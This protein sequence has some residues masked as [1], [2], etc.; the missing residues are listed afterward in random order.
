[1]AYL[2]I[3]LVS[4]LRYR[5]IE[6]CLARFLSASLPNPEKLYFP[7]SATFL[8]LLESSFETK[9]PTSRYS[10]HKTSVPDIFQQCECSVL[11]FSL[12]SNWESADIFLHSLWY[13]HYNHW[14]W[15]MLV[16]LDM[17][18]RYEHTQPSIC[19]CNFEEAPKY[20]AYNI[21]CRFL[22]H[23]P[24]CIQA[25]PSPPLSF[26][27]FPFQE[28]IYDMPLILSDSHSLP[29]SLYSTYSVIVKA[30]PH[31]WG[32]RLADK[33]F[34]RCNCKNR[35]FT[36][37]KSRF[38]QAA[39]GGKGIRQMVAEWISVPVVWFPT[40]IAV[41]RPSASCS[42]LYTTSFAAF[43]SV[44]WRISTRFPRCSS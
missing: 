1:M 40:L 2:G 23:T 36:G 16:P 13:T 42:K 37:S 35:R 10:I 19:T 22:W 39:D 33:F 32:G 3:P 41:W 28:E 17:P 4:P 29:L 21:I 43:P 31:K 34:V 25:I 8:I 9:Q 24:G 7:T 6:S 30:T 26:L 14:G 20:L 18:T 27:F 11:S 38:L 12:Y 15:K 44:L 5:H